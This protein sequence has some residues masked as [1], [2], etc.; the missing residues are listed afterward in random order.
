MPSGPR[1]RPYIH[2]VEYYSLLKRARDADRTYNV[3]EPKAQRKKPFSN[4]VR[5]F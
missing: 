4:K 5:L 2:T 3:D 1:V